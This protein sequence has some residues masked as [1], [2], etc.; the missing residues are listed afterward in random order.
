[1]TGLTETVETTHGRIQGTFESNGVRVF[2]GVPYGADTGGANRFLPPKSPEP[3]TGVR[4]ATTFGPA[5]PTDPSA[6]ADGSQLGLDLFNEAAQEILD[7]D[8][9]TLNVWTPSTT[10]DARRPVMVWF[11]GGA[12]AIGSGHDAP[13]HGYAIARRD[14]AVVV[15]ITHRL[16]IFGHLYLGDAFGDE[17]R[18]SGNVG[19]LDLAAGLAW[20][21]DNIAAF[22]GDPQNVT[23]FGSSG[24]GAKIAFSMAM[25]AFDGLYR[26]AIIQSGH[27]LWKHNSPEAAKG[28]SQLVL[29]QLGIATGE[30]HKL[31]ELS[32]DDLTAACTVAAR[33]MVRDPAAGATPSVNWDWFCPVIDGVDIPQHPQAAIASGSRSDVDLMIGSARFDHWN[34]LAEIDHGL[35]HPRT[36]GTMTDD[37]LREALRPAIGEST[38]TIV[39]VYRA[40][41][42][43]VPASI[44]YATIVTD[45]DWRVPSIRLAEAKIAGG[46]SAPRVYFDKTAQVPEIIFDN[47]PRVGA[48]PGLLSQVGPAWAGFVRAGDPNHDDMPNWPRYSLEDRSTMVL[49][50]ETLVED[51]PHGTE[52]TVWIGIR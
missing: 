28:F 33:A 21:R 51:D 23:I 31:R 30:A 34:G 8:C 1:M 14:D 18:S 49:D 12:F 39:D 11:H 19:M 24:G 13:Y 20:V 6:A 48:A 22:G 40:E 29:D 50:F 9:L 45:R 46:G 41:N 5:C 17:Y 36:F 3:W 38:N 44:L 26:R 52:R 35:G 42:P 16:N 4:E 10:D 32:T 15:S 37:D 25:P 43:F 7:E 47:L 2:R 27:D